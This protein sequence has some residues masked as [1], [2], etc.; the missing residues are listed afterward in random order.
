MSQF[1]TLER[2]ITTS[3]PP[4]VSVR[5]LSSNPTV[6]SLSDVLRDAEDDENVR[7]KRNE[8]SKAKQKS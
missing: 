1:P 6:I 2:V 7:N 3:K 4:T 5:L 8:T